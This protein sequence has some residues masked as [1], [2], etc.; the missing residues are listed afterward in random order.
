MC[1]EYDQSNIQYPQYEEDSDKKQEY[2]VS[3]SGRINITPT[4][5]IETII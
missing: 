1:H 2:T 3:C 5:I 4:N